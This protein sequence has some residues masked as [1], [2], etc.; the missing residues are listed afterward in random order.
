MYLSDSERSAVSRILAALST[1]VRLLFFE[2][3]VG[4]ESCTPT[5]QLL[6]QIAELSGHITLDKLNL[7]LD[8]AKAAHYGI[9]RVPAIVI[10][11]PGTDRIRFYGAPFGSELMS[12]AGAIRMTG[13]RD[14]GLSE[15]SRERLK[16][17]SKPVDV[18]VF[19]TPTCVY[20]PQMITLASGMAV[21]SPL[22]KATAI[23]ATEYPDLV[24]HYHVNGVPKI[25][26]NDTVGIVGVASEDDLIAAIC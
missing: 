18:K 19:F 5:R 17:V 13:T 9:D 23:D 10:A 11:A 15:R 21:E 24:R 8:T 16:T 7:V 14:T 1:P 2:Q 12:F 20:C 26:I 4:C 6:E 3:S 25:V 22:V